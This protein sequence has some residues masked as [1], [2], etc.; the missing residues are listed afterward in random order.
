[1]SDIKKIGT[2][3]PIKNK[4]VGIYCQSWCFNYITDDGEYVGCLATETMHDFLIKKFDLFIKQNTIV[5]QSLSKEQHD[6]IQAAFLNGAASSTDYLMNI[7]NVLNQT[8]I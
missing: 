1:M 6:L 8:T 5:G 7:R 2:L 3:C 4:T